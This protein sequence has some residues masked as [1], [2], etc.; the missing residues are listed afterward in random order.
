MRRGASGSL[1]VG[2]GN[3]QV[4]VTKR[5]ANI[6]DEYIVFSRLWD[7]DFVHLDLVG[8]LIIMVNKL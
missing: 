8:H 3:Y 1:S 5:C 7:W 2:R 6:L 4:R